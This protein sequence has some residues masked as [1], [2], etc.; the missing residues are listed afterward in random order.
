MENELN[1]NL[2]L[3]TSYLFIFSQNRN[4]L[5]QRFISIN[6]CFLFIYLITVKIEVYF[7]NEEKKD[8]KKKD[9][10][11]ADTSRATTRPI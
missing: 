8:K 5:I 7:D 10:N 6:E 9:K 11:W 2:L 1:I 3:H 4:K